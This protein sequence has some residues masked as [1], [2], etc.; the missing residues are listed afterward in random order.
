MY[1]IAVI[2]IIFFDCDG[3]LVCFDNPHIR[4]AVVDSLKKI[5][6]QG[7]KLIIATG[8]APWSVS[9]FDEA[10]FDGLMAFNG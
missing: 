9:V 3:T 2:K 5:H 7:I 8:R 10:P 4:P 1:N 6:E